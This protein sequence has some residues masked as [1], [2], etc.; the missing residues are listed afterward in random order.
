MQSEK[1]LLTRLTQACE[2][3]MQILVKTLAGKKFTLVVERYDSIQQVTQ[4]IQDKEGIPAYKQ[5]LIY[6]G[7]SLDYSR[8]IAD[9]DIQNE[10]ILHLVLRLR[11]YDREEITL[12]EERKQKRLEEERE[13]K[14]LEQERK[15]KRL[16]KEREVKRLEE[17]RKKKRLEEER[18]EKRLEE[19]RKKKHL[20]EER[21]KKR[22]EQERK[23]KRLEKERGKKRLEQERKQKRLEQEREEKRLE[24]EWK[25]KCLEQER[26]KKQ[27]EIIAIIQELNPDISERILNFL[28]IF[29]NRQED[30][31]KQIQ[32]GVIPVGFSDDHLWPSMKNISNKLKSKESRSSKY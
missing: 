1:I 13:E 10:S 28:T 7:K 11:G 24:E 19:E 17:E 27:E 31:L 23:Q 20:E 22:L 21:E 4:K 14:R 9:Y 15:Q 16:E 25:N 2:Q 26:R 3:R 8:T 18:E 12:E 29:T 32:E 5:K 30:I 6:K